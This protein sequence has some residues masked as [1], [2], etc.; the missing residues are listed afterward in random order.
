M[1]TQGHAVMKRIALFAHYDRDGI[2]DDYVI[3]Y[4]RGLTR[5]AEKSCLFPIVNCATEKLPSSKA[6]PSLRSQNR[7]ANMTSEAGNGVSHI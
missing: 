1:G 6:L 4:L 2:I 7:T 3:Y 5:V